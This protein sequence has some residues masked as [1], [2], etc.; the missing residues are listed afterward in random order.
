MEQENSIIKKMAK[1]DGVSNTRVISEIASNIQRSDTPNLICGMK[2]KNALKIAFRRGKRKVN[3][4]PATPKTS[5]FCFNHHDY[6]FS[7]RKF[8]KTNDGKDFLRL[9]SWTK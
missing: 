7:Y 9:K 6:Q 8:S 4:T 5:R 1:V 3:L 2:S